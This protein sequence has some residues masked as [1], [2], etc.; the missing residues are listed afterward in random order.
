[1]REAHKIAKQ[2]GQKYRD[3]IAETRARKGIKPPFKV[4]A[5]VLQYLPRE[6]RTKL[7]DNYDGPWII[8]KR[9]DP[10]GATIGNTYV[11]KNKSEELVRPQSDLKP[12]IKPAFPKPKD[13]QPDTREETT[14]VMAEEHKNQTNP[15]HVELWLSVAQLIANQGVVCPIVQNPAP[16]AQEI[17]PAIDIATDANDGQDSHEDSTI[18]AAISHEQIAAQA[19]SEEIHNLLA[20]ED[21]DNQ[22]SDEG[23]NSKNRN[24]ITLNNEQ[25]RLGASSMEFDT[26]DEE[27]SL[28]GSTTIQ[29][30]T[31]ISSEESTHFS[32]E[33]PNTPPRFT[34]TPDRKSYLAGNGQRAK[35]TH[36]KGL[37]SKPTPDDNDNDNDD[38]LRL[39]HGPQGAEGLA[40]TPPTLE[41]T[42][43]TWREMRRLESYNRAGLQERSL[44]GLE[45]KRKKKS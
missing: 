8:K 42:K 3:K 4:G 13:E 26:A 36:D 37:K 16:A 30:T 41:P 14:K 18:E 27:S 38:I 10:P 7:S 32:G 21:E 29:R 25:D 45:R 1:M 12:Y 20:Q 11:I 9:L 31:D 39:D 6:A 33:G 2:Q 17:R 28:T 5:K 19:N 35:R 24:P 40:Q 43:E 23:E 34:S 15:G 22:M 44:E